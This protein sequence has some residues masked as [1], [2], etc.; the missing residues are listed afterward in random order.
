MALLAI[1]G[2]YKLSDPAPTIGALRGAGLP[3]S[4]G[5]VWLLALAE[6]AVAGVWFA[7]GGRIAALAGAGL[8]IGFALFVTFALRRDLPIASC[9]CLGR[10]DTPPTWLHVIVNSL[11]AV[12]L[13]WAAIVPTG[14][15]AGLPDES[16]A[17][18]IPFL[19]FSGT[20][21]YLLYAVIAVL[22]EKAAASREVFVPLTV[23]RAPGA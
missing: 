1:A 8:Y 7:V 16:L 3:H 11:S 19:I 13:I 22:P 23:G 10:A 17:V 21:V 14:P 4:R 20:V 18:A 5:V 9:G 15:L 6:V 2:I 12:V